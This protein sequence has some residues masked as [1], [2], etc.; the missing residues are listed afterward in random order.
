MSE[1]N[2]LIV[3]KDVQLTYGTKNKTVAALKDINLKI[4]KGEFLCILGP[5]GCGKS[6]MLN[7]IA[8]FLK[9][10][11]GE[12]LM[13]GAPI[14]GPDCH[15]GVMFQESN[16]YPWLTVGRNVEFGP[17]IRKVDKD[18]IREIRQ[19]YLKQVQLEGFEEKRVFELSGGMKQ[20]CA[21]A[22]VLANE[23]EVILM[24]EPFGALDALT[25]TNMQ[26]LM[27]TVW[28]ENNN[29]VILITHDIDEALTLGTRVIVMSKRPG[30][31]VKDIPLN[32][33]EEIYRDNQ[34]ERIKYTDE[35]FKIREEVL[36]VINR[37]HEN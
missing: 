24:D 29:T 14:N 7:I 9:Q 21:L 35:Y 1:D 11:E 18:K 20:R 13:D 5:S 3:L 17:K 30:R 4:R 6:T 26:Q 31:I 27:R 28:K 22:R 25:R 15:R 36:G 12:V 19:Y 16:L 32:F 10:S 34:M 2:A 33:T 8:G 37:Q 23:P